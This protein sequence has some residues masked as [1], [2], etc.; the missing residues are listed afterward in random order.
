MKSIRIT[1][2][3]TFVGVLLLVQGCEQAEEKIEP[4]P[5]VFG[6]TTDNITVDGMTFDVRGV[7]Y[8]PF[9][10]GYLP[11]V[12]EYDN[13]LPDILINRINDDIDSIDAMG[14]NTI[15]LWGAPKYCYDRIAKTTELLI[16]QTIWLEGEHADFRS[17]DFINSSKTIIHEVTQKIFS[18]ISSENPPIFAY[19]IGNELS[20]QSI[21]NTNQAHPGTYS[22][23]GEYIQTDTSLSATELTLAELA[24]YLKQV[25]VSYTS[26]EPLVSYSNEL[27]TYD[28]LDTPFLDFRCYNVYSYAVDYYI[29][30]PPTGSSSG[31]I[32]QGFI[33]QLKNEYP[34]LPLLVTETGLSVNPGGQNIGPPNYG[35]GGNSEDEQAA[36]LIQTINDIETASP[37]I[38]GVIIHEFN[39]AWWKFGLEDS[40]SQDPDDV[41][42]WFGLVAFTGEPSAWNITPRE[43]Y[44]DIRDHWS[45]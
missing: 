44:H 18:T 15:R 19:L 14:V 7:V 8:V 33:E 45:E 40:Y 29:A 6:T 26:V 23:T 35:Y 31:T 30:N 12:F 20:R 25:V 2:L 9:A 41:E 43:A 37:T 42:E 24:D 3:F 5:T 34:E 11:W 21:L 32:T 36:G 27:R 17:P 16:L 10:P 4:V 28:I 38:A 39:D 13:Q 22:F 1:L